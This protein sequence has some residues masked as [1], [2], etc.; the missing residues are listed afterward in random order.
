MTE[1]LTLLFPA[2]PEADELERAARERALAALREATAREEVAPR[3]ARLRR[4]RRWLLVPVAAAAAA[5]AAIIAFTSGLDEGELAPVNSAAAILHRAADA[6]ERS[7]AAGGLTPG[8]Y[9]YVRRT[10]AEQKTVTRR[11][12]TFR[13]LIRHRLEDWTARDG[14]GRSRQRPAALAFPTNA[15]RAAWMRAGSP[16]A[17]ELA[18]DAD[19]QR[20]DRMRPPDREHAFPFW[21]ASNAVSYRAVR[22]L[23][24]DPAQLERSLR[25]ESRTPGTD[26]IAALRLFERIAGL[27]A[28]APL[29]PAQ[30][31]ALYRVTATLPGVHVSN[32]TLVAHGTAVSAEADVQGSHYTVTMVFSL[33]TG[34][35]LATRTIIS[36]RIQ[37][38][39]RV[40][41]DIAVRDSTRA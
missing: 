25:A 30:R 34:R 40:L 11:G 28:G 17:S 23:P 5:A 2:V 10:T 35:L 15:D 20:D 7:P 37:T 29:E 24:T 41:Y 36:G 33:T 16:S 9:L 22:A 19:L 8:Q 3:P 18:G 13:V 39:Y 4:R 31:S 14:S 1:P 12:R 26:G 27:L 21:V 32:D 6:A 38:D